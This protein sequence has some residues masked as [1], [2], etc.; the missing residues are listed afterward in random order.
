M[1]RPI[2][3]GGVL[4]KRAT[5]HNADEIARKDI[6]I[7]DTVIIQRAGDVIPQVVEVVAGEAAGGSAPYRFPGQCP[8]C[9]SRLI[10][11]EQG[12]VD[13]V[14]HRRARLRGAGR[15]TAE[16]LCLPGRVR[17]RGAGREERRAFYAKGLIKTRRWTS[18][19][20]RSA[21]GA[22]LRRCANGTGGARS[23]RAN[24]STPCAAR[25]RSRSTA[26]SYALGIRQVGQAT[27]RLLAQHYLTPGGL[28][29]R[30]WRP[31]ARSAMRKTHAH[32]LSI[33]GIGASMVDDILAF[34]A[35][36]TTARSWTP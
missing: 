36:L 32:L 9:G 19:P 2:N 27:A 35:S 16:A 11:E 21:T 34:V 29:G 26:S 31:R 23:R 14:L 4:V 20:W 5:L 13:T 25:A 17:H 33:N 28:A 1:L 12:E 18:S 10:R 24:C 7:G 22:R 3:V 30:A 15:R 8:V 6:R